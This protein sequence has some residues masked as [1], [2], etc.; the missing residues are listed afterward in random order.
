MHLI[1][2]SQAEEFEGARQS[3]GQRGFLQ[4]H[5]VQPTEQGS[6]VLDTIPKPLQTEADSMSVDIAGSRLGMGLYLPPWEATA[7]QP[8]AGGGGWE[9]QGVRCPAYTIWMG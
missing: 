2:Q 8:H 5:T 9:T 7:W 4:P 3:Q 6:G 1:L